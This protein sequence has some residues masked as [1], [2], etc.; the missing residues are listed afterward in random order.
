ME[1]NWRNQKYEIGTKISGTG[2]SKIIL[3]ILYKT[4]KVYS[5]EL[6]RLLRIL[7]SHLTYACDVFLGILSE[8]S[9]HLFLR[10]YFAFRYTTHRFNMYLLDSVLRFGCKWD[11]IWSLASYNKQHTFV[12]FVCCYRKSDDLHHLVQLRIGMSL[13]WSIIMWK[14]CLIFSA[15]TTPARKILYIKG[16]STEIWLSTGNY[17]KYISIW[18]VE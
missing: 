9:F 8:I 14:F 5:T 17:L 18:L 11:E 2:T 7:R 4:N 3:R 10:A 1:P 12:E 16:R 6:F 13:Y 15:T